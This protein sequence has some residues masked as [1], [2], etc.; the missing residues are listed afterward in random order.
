M[1]DSLLSETAGMHPPVD[2]PAARLAARLADR[3]ADRPAV[4]MVAPMAAPVAAR[5]ARWSRP[6]AGAKARGGAQFRAV[7]IFAP[8]KGGLPIAAPRPVAQR[9]VSPRLKSL[10]RA[11]PLARHKQTGALDAARGLMAI[12]AQ[13]EAAQSG[14][15]QSG[16][17][18]APPARASAAPDFKSSN[19]FGPVFTQTCGLQ[20]CVCQACVCQA[21]VFQA[22]VFQACGCQTCGFQACGCQACVCQTCAAP[23]DVAAPRPFH[24]GAL[25]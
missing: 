14:A 22:R 7:L 2:R 20:T 25:V 1:H 3:L 9:M 6:M 17:A 19:A 15:A 10:T 11:F 12:A 24:H 21:C 23:A 5:P 16:A 13:S 4:P 8:C 18:H